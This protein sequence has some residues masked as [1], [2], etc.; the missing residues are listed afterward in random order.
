MKRRRKKNRIGDAT[1][2]KER[3]K[4][5]NKRG[6]EREKALFEIH[7]R[8][9]RSHFMSSVNLAVVNVTVVN[10]TVAH[11]TVVHVRQA[12]EVLFAFDSFLII[13]IFSSCC[14]SSLTQA[15]DKP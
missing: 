5:E 13:V 6:T 9:M 11:V 15:L 10:V 1:V 2:L 7:K 8:S 4:R 14:N 3:P 12:R